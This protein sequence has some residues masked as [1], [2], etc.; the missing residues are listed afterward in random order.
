MG[1]PVQFSVIVT[2][3]NEDLENLFRVLKDEVMLVNISLYLFVRTS[4]D[5]LNIKIYNQK[6]NHYF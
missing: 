3:N 5:C 4:M 1:M 6:V 2:T